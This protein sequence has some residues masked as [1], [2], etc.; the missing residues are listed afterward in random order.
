MECPFQ[1]E[2]T[3]G[4]LKGYHACTNPSVKRIKCFSIFDCDV[5]PT[6]K[7]LERTEESPFWAEGTRAKTVVVCD[8]KGSR[9]VAVPEAAQLL[10]DF[11]LGA[12][13][14]TGGF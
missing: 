7:D 6:R 4:R 8:S 9:R 10:D 11:F 14:Q 2:T 1:K 13:E 3:L 5:C 12:I